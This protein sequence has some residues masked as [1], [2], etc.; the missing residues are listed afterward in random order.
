M[1]ST[2][3]I[4]HQKTHEK[5]LPRGVIFAFAVEPFIQFLGRTVTNGANWRYF[6]AALIFCSHVSITHTFRQMS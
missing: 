2:V 6:K 3:D 5:L 4:S 1:L